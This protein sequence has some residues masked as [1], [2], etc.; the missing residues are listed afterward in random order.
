MNGSSTTEALSSFEYGGRVTILR[1]AES[2]SDEKLLK[3]IHGFDLFACEAKYHK[4]CRTQ[5]VQKPEK[6][7][8]K[9]DESKMLQ[10]KLE[11]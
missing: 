2:K 9:S 1:E 3:R 4:S 6:W 10:N 5:Y 11:S 8:S 7:H